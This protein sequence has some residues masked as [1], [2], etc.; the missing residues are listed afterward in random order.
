MKKNHGIHGV[1]VRNPVFSP[2]NSKV[3]CRYFAVNLGIICKLSLFQNYALET[4]ARQRVDLARSRFRPGLSRS[5]SRVGGR[6]GR[7]CVAAGRPRL[8]PFPAVGVEACCENAFAAARTLR[9]ALH[10]GRRGAK[11]D[12]GRKRDFRPLPRLPGSD[13]LPLPSPSH[14]HRRRPF[15]RLPF[16]APPTSFNS[17]EGEV[18]SGGVRSQIIR[19]L[20]EIR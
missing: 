20:L 4:C 11:G 7:G 16:Q 19:R 10:G 12:F 18:R 3:I 14:V 15:R 5:V 6:S 17:E 13:P 8:L 1:F 2:C 9:R